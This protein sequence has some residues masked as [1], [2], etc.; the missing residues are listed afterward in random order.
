MINMEGKQ[1]KLQIWDTVCT[2][3]CLA[4]GEPVISL[5][6]SNLGF[7]GCLKLS[8]GLRQPTCFASFLAEFLSAQ[9]L[10]SYLCCLR[11]GRSHSGVSRVPTT[12]VPQEH[13]WFMTSP[14]APLLHVFRRN[15]NRGIHTAFLSPQHLRA[16]H[17]FSAR[18]V[19]LPF[20]KHPVSKPVSYGPINKVC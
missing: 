10:T 9:L 7:Q 4:G 15:Y 12:G 3:F 11:L 20:V 19:E 1:I 16:L 5:Q 13:F 17:T 14:G 6:M 18:V 8:Y 2:P